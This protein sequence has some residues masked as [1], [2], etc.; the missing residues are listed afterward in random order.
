MVQLDR[1]EDAR[2][3]L[4]QVVAEH[5]KS[6]AAAKAKARLAELFPA[7]DAKKVPPKKK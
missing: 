2:A 6:E 3:F 4:E 1:K 5:P 7:K